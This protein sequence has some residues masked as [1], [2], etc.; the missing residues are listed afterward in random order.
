MNEYNI[1]YL[2][3]GNLACLILACLF[4]MLGGR[5]GKWRRRFVAPIFIAVALNVSSLLLSKYSFYLLLAYPLS[6]A[7]FILG[8]GGD[9]KIARI[10][11][12]ILVAILSV[13]IGVLLCIL[14][15]SGWWLL[16]INFLVAIGSVMFAIK[17]P[18]AAASEEVLVCALL[19]LVMMFYPFIV[20]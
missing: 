6:M 12:R 20:R 7:M 2:A 4:Y 13:F 5:S 14:F 1:G 3:V 15:Q 10:I 19:N 8:Y 18:I 17:N 11:K 9:D 16:A